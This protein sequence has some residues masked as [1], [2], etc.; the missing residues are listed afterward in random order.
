[1]VDDGLSELLSV[2][3]DLRECGSRDSLEGKFGFLYTENKKANCTSIDD[4]LSE[5]VVVLGDAGEG[6]SGSL[7]D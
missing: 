7:L 4:S 3:C 5:F 2:L 6:K 1:M